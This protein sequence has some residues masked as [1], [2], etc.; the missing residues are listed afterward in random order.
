MARRC[1]ILFVWSGKIKAYIDLITLHNVSSTTGSNR[2]ETQTSIHKWSPPP[3]GLSR[4]M[5]MLRFSPDQDEQPAASWCTIIRGCYWRQIDVHLIISKAQKWLKL[6]LFVRPSSLPK[7]SRI[8]EVAGT[9]QPPD[10]DKQ[11][12]KMQTSTDPLSER[13][14]RILNLPLQSSYLVISSML[15][16]R[17]WC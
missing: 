4:S 17:T 1:L 8:S 3:N 2:C 12:A 15:I 9:L 7:K 14:S 16:C 10:A 11:G 6:S 5:W 13:L